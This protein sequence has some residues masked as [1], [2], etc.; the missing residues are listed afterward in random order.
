M[1]RA[2]RNN[3]LQRDNVWKNLDWLSIGAY[4]LLVFLGWLNIYAV[5]Q[6]DMASGVWLD[7]NTQAG[8]QLFWILICIAVFFVM[9]LIDNKVIRY[10]SYFVYGA[11]LLASVAVLFLGA[12]TKGAVSWFA[13][14]G[15]KIQPSEFAKLGT[16]MALAT[17]LNNPKKI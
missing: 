11:T 8:K 16:A 1:A 4:L 9:M 14:G 6:N 7:F 5:T 3:S 13:I 2:S 15:V 12:E 10:T 17:Y